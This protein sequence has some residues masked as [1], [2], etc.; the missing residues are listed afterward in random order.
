GLAGLRGEQ[1]AA[2]PVGPPGNPGTPGD[3]GEAGAPGRDGR[4]GLK[5]DS[6]L[7]GIVG[8]SGPPGPP[9]VPGSIGPPGQVLYVKGADAAPIPGPQGPPGTPGVPG[10]PGAVGARGDPG[11]NG[12]PGK[13]GTAAVSNLKVVVDKR[14]LLVAPTVQK[15]ERGD[16]GG[17]G[18]PGLRGQPGSD[19]SQGFPGERGAKGDQG[20]RG[21]AGAPG[22]PGRAI[23]ERG[24]EGPPGTAGDPGKPG[25]PGVPGRAGE[26]GETGR[27][28]GQWTKSTDWFTW[29]QGS[30]W[31]SWRK[32]RAWGYRTTWTQRRTSKINA[33]ESRSL[34]SLNSLLSPQL[35]LIESLFLC[36]PSSFTVP[37]LFLCICFYSVLQGLV[38]PRGDKG[39]RGDPGERGRDGPQ[40]TAGEPGKSG[41]DGPAWLPRNSRQTGKSRRARPEGLDWSTGPPRSVRPGGHC[42]TSRP[43]GFK[44]GAGRQ[45]SSREGCSWTAWTQRREGTVGERGLPGEKGEAGESGEPGEDG[46]PGSSGPKGD[47]GERGVGLAGPGGQVGPP[48]LKGKPGH[49]G[50]PGLRGEIGQTGPPGPPGNVGVQGFA[51]SPG[52]TGPPGPPGPPGQA[53]EVG[54]GLPGPRGERGDPGPRGEEGRPGLDGDRGLQGPGGIRGPRGEKGDVGPQGDKG[55][56]G[57]TVLVGGP[58]GEKGNNGEQV[59][60]R[61]DGSKGDRGFKGAQ[62]EKGV[63]GQDG[64]PGEQV[65]VAPMDKRETVASLEYLG[66]PGKDGLLG[67]KGDKGEFGAVGLRGIKG[68]RG[69]KGT[70]GGDGPKG[71]KGDAGINGRPGLPGRKGEQG[72]VGAA[73]APGIPGKEG[74]VGPKGDRGFDGLAGPKGTQG[75]KGDRGP[76]GVPGPTGP[77]GVDGAPGL[78]GSQ[79]PPGEKGPEGLQGQ[80]GERGPAGPAVVG[81]RGIPGIPGERGEPGEM[82]PDGAKGERGELGMTE[83]EV[84]Q[85]IRSEMS[86]H[87]GRELHMVVNTNDPDYEHIYSVESYNDNADELLYITPPGGTVQEPDKTDDFELNTSS[88]VSV[89]E[90]TIDAEQ[91]TVRVSPK[92][93]RSVRFKRRT[94]GK[95]V[96]LL[97]LEEGSC[98]RY[99]LRW[100]FNSQA[101]ACRPFV[102][103]GCEGNDNRFLHLE[104]CEEVCLLEAGE[105][106]CTG[107]QQALPTNADPQL[108]LM[109][110]PAASSSQLIGQ[111]DG[112]AVFTSP[113][114]LPP[115]EIRREQRRRNTPDLLGAARYVDIHLRAPPP[116]LTGKTN[117]S[118][119]GKDGDSAFKLPTGGLLRRWSAVA[120]METEA[121]R[122]LLETS[123]GQGAGLLDGRGEVGLEE[124]WSSP[125]PLGFQVSLTTVLMLELVLGFS[126]NLTVLVLYCAQSNLVDS[127]SNLVTVNLHVLDILVCVLCLP[128]TVAVILLPANGSEACVTFT[129]V[130]TAVNVLVIS[131]DRYD[132][133]VRPASRLLTPR[134]AA[135][136]LA[137]VWAL[138]LA[139]FFLPFLEGDF[140]SSSDEDDEPSEPRNENFELTTGFNRMFPS[141]SPSPSPTPNP[142]SSSHHLNPAWQNRTLLCVGGQGYYTGLAIYYPPA[143]S[144]A[145]LLHRRGGHVVHVLQNP[146]GPQHPY[147][148]SHDEEH[149]GQGVQLQDTLPEEKKKHL[150]LPT[151]ASVSAIIALRRAVRRHRDRRERQ[152]RVLKMSLIIVSTFLGCWAPLSA[153]N[154]LIL[155]LGPSDGLVRLRLC[156]LVMAYGTTI[157]HPLLYAFTRQKLR[158]ALKTRVKKRVVSLLQV[159]PAPSG[160]TVIHNSWVEGGGQRKTRKPRVEASDGTD[161]CLTEVV[162]E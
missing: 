149:T 117:R 63:K 118:L 98:G 85:Y 58:P 158:R 110:A 50:P 46:A 131:L 7:G 143:A 42:W 47:K 160:G 142:S 67:R 120:P 86:Q 16:K 113:W 36:Y 17:P 15:G 76:P 66:L 12:V 81:P 108:K 64:P 14:D 34:P 18:A 157:F 139:V 145:V 109:E 129:S 161:R 73:G 6:G 23:G 45:W 51:G 153:V 80:K 30:S 154:V 159:D 35:L 122:D 5:G 87:C 94:S 31:C 125:Y 32:R 127:V 155:C 137:A 96:C 148:L 99:T 72:D 97:P 126:S 68:D 123:D 151:E 38:G 105:P 10:I 24:P 134:R 57:D 79:G 3:K 136:L 111:D 146:A 141:F 133:S 78:T 25:I 60:D 27:P 107:G 65:P 144:S 93:T 8:P 104:E 49:I 83:D 88:N 4:D 147:R 11:E 112:D 130:A 56:K 55:D 20:E 140:F 2:G 91:K 41:Q 44:G 119:E 100:Y 138:S 62:G 43:V 114:S 121:Y 9:G 21:P 22:P 115:H 59:S 103:S 90:P 1:G 70:C 162:R 106:L 89:A 37:S 54:V 116:S 77:R 95:D 92:A 82:G 75:E 152:R 48:G 39:D 29:G 102:Y 150:S 71:E 19:G 53:G 40:G 69:P 52:K 101:Q 128:L 61:P 74:L 124:G 26:Q 156:F 13:P 33:V 28:G 132:I 135:L 84:R